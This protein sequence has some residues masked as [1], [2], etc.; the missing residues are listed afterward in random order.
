MI[1]GE[2]TLAGES[3]WAIKRCSRSSILGICNSKE[4]NFTSQNQPQLHQVPEHPIMILFTKKCILYLYDDPLVITLKAATA[5][6]ARTLVDT[7]SFVDIIFK[8]A[9]G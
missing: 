7:D 1:A 4:V 6:A 5:K 3:K 8:S 9:L 2:L